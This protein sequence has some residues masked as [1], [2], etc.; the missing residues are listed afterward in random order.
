MELVYRL[1]CGLYHL[2]K[3]ILGRSVEHNDLQLQRREKIRIGAEAEA[4]P[5]LWRNFIRASEIS[6]GE[7]QHNLH[8]GYIAD[9]SS[10]CLPSWIWTN[11]AAV[12]CL[13]EEGCLD[14]ACRLGELLLSEQCSCGGWVVRN[15]YDRSGAKPMLAPNDSAY[16]ANNAC[17]TLYMHTRDVKYL[18]AARRCADWIINTARPDGMVYLGYNMRDERWE[19]DCVIVDVGFTAGLF[20]R[21]YELTQEGSYKSYLKRFT[22]RYIELFYEPGS[23]CFATSIDRNDKR[24]GGLFGRGQAWALEGLVPAYRITQD[25][26]LR[27]V[28]EANVEALLQQQLRNGAWPYNLAKPLMGEDCKAVSV[29]AKDLMDWYVIHPS[30][31]I[32][33]AAQKALDWCCQHTA[34]SGEAAGGI[35]SYCLEGAIVHNLYTS[36]AFVYA[37]AYAIELVKQLKQCTQ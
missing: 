33:I 26:R 9:C 19:N 11:A 23:H 1:Y 3:R 10:W 14:E 16:I 21:L 37:S 18:N 13:C 6:G 4:A 30:P 5:E 17:L 22:E 7:W 20:A 31:D 34:T 35:F 27:I 24:Q 32:Y 12:R 15:D 29:I 28:I 2:A 8:A 25:E 36:T